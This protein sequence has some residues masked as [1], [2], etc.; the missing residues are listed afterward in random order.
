M[1]HIQ[2]TQGKVALV[3]DEDYEWLS[4][5]KWHYTHQGYAARRASGR[6]VLMHREIVGTEGSADTDHI[7][8]NKLDNRRCNL[9]VC[10]RSQNLINRPSLRGSSNY[11]GVSWS[12]RDRK[13]LAH[14]YH[15]GKSHYI[16][17]FDDEREAAA[18]YDKA[19]KRAFGEFARLNFPE[20]S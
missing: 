14:S 6:M 5:S 19:A 11:K 4:Q 17:T 2:L 1:K 16:G 10:T 3:D 12:V 9:R 18:A 8:G 13:W 20:E 15:S 7:N